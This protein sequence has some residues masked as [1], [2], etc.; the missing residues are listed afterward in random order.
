MPADD[1]NALAASYRQELLAHCYRMLGSVH[2]AEDLVQETLLRGWRGYDRFDGRSSL[3]TW[4]YRIATNACLSAL[5]STHRRVLPSGLG[6][7]TDNGGVDLV[8]A[9]E[10]SWLTPLPTSERAGQAQD[11]SEVTML[12]ASTRLALVAAF[13]RLPARQRAVLLLVDVVG[14]RTAEAAEFLGIT[15]NA[16]RSLLQR[17]RAALADDPPAED[18][19]SA[20]PELDEK[21]L[22]RYLDAFEAADIRRLAELLRDGV[23][24]EMPPIATWFRGR[25][26]VREHWTR[27]VFR[28]PRRALPLWAN[29]C[30]AVATYV[31]GSDGDF[32][33]HAIEVLEIQ[34]GLISRVVVFLHPDLFPR[35]GV[36]RTLSGTTG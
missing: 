35:F 19:V 24:Y 13:Q 18:D 22:R 26:A 9:D 23:T 10:V 30:P 16:G 25:D 31:Q 36:P 6:T 12:R 28:Q 15:V 11:P 27:R 8:R 29:G 17:A 1:F 33:A 21:V 5:A 34:G 14:L 7:A 32:R 4:L 20:D 3:R 2:D